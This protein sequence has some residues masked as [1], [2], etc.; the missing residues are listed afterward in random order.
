[1]SYR[2][3]SEEKPRL[4]LPPKM[5]FATTLA[6][7]HPVTNSYFILERKNGEYMQCGGGPDRC[8]VEVCL[9][10][11][12]GGMTRHTF[13]KG[14]EDVTAAE[15]AMSDGF[16]PVRA[17]EV[18]NLDDAVR[19]F[20]NFF[21]GAALLPGYR[22]RV[23]EVWPNPQ[24]LYYDD[25]AQG[26]THETSHPRFRDLCADAFFLDGNNDFAPFGSDDGH[27]TL[28]ALETWFRDGGSHNTP[29]FLE[30]LLEEWDFGIGLEILSSKPVQ[31][32]AWLREKDMHSRYLAAVCRATVATALG[33]LKI[34]GGVDPDIQLLALQA[35]QVQR[36]ANTRA[37]QVHPDWRYADE[38][39][40][41]LDRIEAVLR[42]PSPS[43]GDCLF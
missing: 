12:Q 24:Q 32:D 10:N 41:G 2:L 1:M 20:E 40:S 9:S 30:Q 3:Q 14:S 16:T 7:L 4:P 31:I 33:Q 15:I 39:I 43:T 25:S 22:L 29:A 37:R 8:T 27:D 38:E 26:S 17:D 34:A 6:R 23:R 28:R 19:L 11:P 18:L 21:A 5:S 42:A 13:G 36:D 35:V